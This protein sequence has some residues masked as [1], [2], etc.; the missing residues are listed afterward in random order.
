EGV[1]WD[2]L[3]VAAGVGVAV[4]LGHAVYSRVRRK[5][6]GVA[7]VPGAEERIERH[8][9]VDRWFHWLTALCVLTLLL[10]AF[11]PII[12]VKFAWVTIH[13]I[14]GVL[15]VILVL[16]HTVRATF[17]QHLRHIWIRW[18][19]LKRPLRAGKYS[20]AQKLMHEAMTAAIIAV[21]VTGVLMLLKIDTPFWK[22]NPYVFKADVWGFIYV[23]HGLAALLALTLVIVHIYF[24]L[25]P[26]NRMYLRA[27]LRGW[28]TRGEAAA[29]HDPER[30][31]KPGP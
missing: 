9:A 11:L 31:P 25:I 7:N 28:V 12:G 6:P 14:S 26:E 17:W 18:R 13:W 21:G 4:I 24:A 10:T 5:P 16:F 30:W 8:A 22:R 1:S 23:L 3:P 2:L 15:A 29:R 20:L 19:D 27:M